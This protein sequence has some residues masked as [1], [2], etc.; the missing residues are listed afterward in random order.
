[1]FGPSKK[2]LYINIIKFIELLGLGKSE[3]QTLGSRVTK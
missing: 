3:S 1:M 2:Y